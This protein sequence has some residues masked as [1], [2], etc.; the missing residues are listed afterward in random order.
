MLDPDF[1]DQLACPICTSAFV[2]SEQDERLLCHSCG[3]AFPVQ[4]GIPLLLPENAEP[5]TLVENCGSGR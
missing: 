4:D 3:V 5:Y 1:I 2:S